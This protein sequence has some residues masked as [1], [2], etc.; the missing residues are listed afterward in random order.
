MELGLFSLLNAYEDGVLVVSDDVSR[1]DASEI[2]AD[3]GVMRA[4][5]EQSADME[6]LNKLMGEHYEHPELRRTRG[7]GDGS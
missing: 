6:L 3:A 1:E 5:L 2:F 4:L 7:E